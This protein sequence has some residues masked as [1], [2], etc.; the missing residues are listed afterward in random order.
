MLSLL[1]TRILLNLFSW[2]PQCTQGSP[3]AKSPDEWSVTTKTAW[4]QMQHLKIR[5][6]VQVLGAW[7]WHDARARHIVAIF[8]TYWL[9]RL[10]H[11]L[12]LIARMY[13]CVL[14][15]T[16]LLQD[17]LLLTCLWCVHWWLEFCS[18]WP[19]YLCTY[20]PMSGISKW[21]W[22][23][24]FLLQS[25]QQLCW[26]GAFIWTEVTLLSSQVQVQLRL[27]CVWTSS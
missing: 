19:R 11:F 3:W 10:K 18:L 9:Q 25:S 21:S 24:S 26:F 2:V 8:Q 5:Y 6:C 22:T 1:I 16:A 17:F 14:I 15:N 7:T 27:W 4:I 12:Y 20:L 13:M 23:C